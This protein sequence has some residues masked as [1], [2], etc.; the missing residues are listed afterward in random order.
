[1][2]LPAP[3]SLLQFSLRQTQRTGFA[4]V[5]SSRIASQLL[6]VS[7]IYALCLQCVLLPRVAIAAL[8]LNAKTTAAPK[9]F[10][11]NEAANE[12][13]NNGAS[14][15]EASEMPA[16]GDTL[17]A[18][19]TDAVVSKHRPTLNSG[20]IE[21]TLRVLLG[22]LFT[23][24]G[25]NQITSDLYL[26]G[27]PAIQSSGAARYAGTVSD[28]GTNSPSN[29]TVSLSGDVDLPGKIHTQVDPVTLPADFPASIPAA[30]GT[31]TISIHSQSDIA[32]IGSWQTVRD[33]SVSRSGL[34]VNVPPGNYGTFTV[35]G[36]SRLNFTAGTYNFANTFNLDGSASIQA[37]GLVVINVAKSLT[38]TSGALVLGSYTSPGDVRLNV[39]GPSVNVNGS[40]QISCLLR[41]DNATANINGAAQVRGYWILDPDTTHGISAHRLTSAELG[42][43]P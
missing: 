24:N 13:T 22:E 27:T 11:E 20:R 36:N 30:S 38:V 7:L 12:V 26:P 37:T 41:A 35:N 6:A 33:L 39:L 15:N 42:P 5:A 4:S 28:G 18:T 19:I 21:G 9:Q 10:A 17:A 29:Y 23:I 31:R 32:G 25:T 1:M 2:S 34:T 43:R 8:S 14:G 40:S 16:G 3:L